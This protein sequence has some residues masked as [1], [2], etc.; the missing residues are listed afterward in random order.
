MYCQTKLLEICHFWFSQALPKE[1]FDMGP[2]IYVSEL[3]VISVH[4][5]AVVIDLSRFKVLNTFSN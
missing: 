1:K 2:Q 5:L 4:I 3:F